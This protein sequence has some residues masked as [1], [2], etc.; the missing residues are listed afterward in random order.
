[1]LGHPLV[2]HLSEYL[3]LN[4]FGVVDIADRP[5]KENR[6]GRLRLVKLLMVDY[7]AGLVIDTTIT[8]DR[9]LVLISRSVK[10]VVIVIEDD[11]LFIRGKRPITID[12]IVELKGHIPELIGSSNKLGEVCLNGVID[13]NFSSLIHIKDNLDLVLR[14]F[15]S[16]DGGNETLEKVTMVS[17]GCASDHDKLH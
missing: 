16:R 6:H 14:A 5:G 4:S 3:D 2:L 11:T 7:R 15:R 8:D 12:V 1:V 10:G 17:A 13:G 9:V